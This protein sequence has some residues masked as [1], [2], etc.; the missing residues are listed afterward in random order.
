MNSERKEEMLALA[1]A[2]AIAAPAETGAAECVAIAEEIANSGMTLEQ[3]LR[4]KER[5]QAMI[6]GGEL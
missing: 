1:L 6:E 5:A 4:A 2:L 3:V